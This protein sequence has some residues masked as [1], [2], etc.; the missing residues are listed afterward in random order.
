[1]RKFVQIK[2]LVNMYWI[3]LWPGPA[4]FRWTK[5]SWGYAVEADD[6]HF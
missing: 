5:I 6:I 1:M 3:L 4:Y 2:L